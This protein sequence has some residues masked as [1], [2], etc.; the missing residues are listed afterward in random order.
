MSDG[1]GVVVPVA[2]GFDLARSF[3]LQRM[4]RGD[5]TARLEGDRFIK[6]ARTPEGPAAVELV[7]TRETWTARVQAWGEGA[8]WV[9]ARAAAWLGANDDPT[10]FQPAAGSPLARLHAEHR[11]IRLP[12]SPF[13][14]ELHAALVLQQ[15]V[16]WVEACGSHHRLALDYGT[17]APGPL[18]LRLFP[19]RK[20]LAGLP[21]H[22]FL[23]LGVDAKRGGA[24]VEAARLGD[25]VDRLD[26]LEAARSYL[27]KIPGTGPWTTEN[28]M[29]HGFADP[30]AVPPGDVNLPHAVCWALAGETFGSD[31]RMFEVLEPYRGHRGRVVRLL[32]LG[33]PTRPYIDRGRNAAVAHRPGARPGFRSSR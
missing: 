4:G 19:D 29:A 14:S 9:L 11:G 6:A 32:H 1:D 30:D 7:I 8:G 33:G 26:G 5:P 18:G 2:Q 27:M 10:A 12:R 3:I 16:T 21:R 24:L 15:R 25:R 13:V 23:S 20:V 22:T 17:D 31:A 28:L